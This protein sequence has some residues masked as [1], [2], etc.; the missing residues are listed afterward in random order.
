MSTSRL[1]AEALAVLRHFVRAEAKHVGADIDLG[2]VH[3]TFARLGRDPAAALGVL[4]ERG[5]VR[6]ADERVTLTAVGADFFA[7]HHHSCH[8]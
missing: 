8:A 5:I 6:V 7:R 1:P 3:T 4:T 2:D